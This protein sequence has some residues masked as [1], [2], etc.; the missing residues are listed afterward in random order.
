VGPAWLCL[1]QHVSLQTSELSAQL[2]G[3]QRPHCHFAERRRCVQRSRQ[4]ISCRGAQRGDCP[5]CEEVLGTIGLRNGVRSLHQT[6]HVG[7]RKPPG[8]QHPPSVSV[9]S[10][11]FSSPRVQDR[12]SAACPPGLTLSSA[13]SCNHQELQVFHSLQHQLAVA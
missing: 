7:P 10:L 1:T 11:Y 12:K 6:Q 5:A 2:R 13:E 4:L 3:R 9:T 8:H